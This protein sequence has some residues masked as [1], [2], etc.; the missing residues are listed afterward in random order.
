MLFRT[1]FTELRRRFLQLCDTRVLL[2]SFRKSTI[3]PVARTV[4]WSLAVFALVGTTTAGSAAD[5]PAPKPKLV[6]YTKGT[7]GIGIPEGWKELTFVL[8]QDASG[9]GPSTGITSSRQPW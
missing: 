4:A 1:V 5:P 9:A 3:G 8:P 2:V 6:K 7:V